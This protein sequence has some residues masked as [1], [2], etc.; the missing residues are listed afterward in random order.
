MTKRLGPSLLRIRP[1]DFKEERLP[2]EIREMVYVALIRTTCRN[3]TIGAFRVLACLRST[4]RACHRLVHHNFLV[5]LLEALYQRKPQVGSLSIRDSN[6][7]L[8]LVPYTKQVFAT[9]WSLFG[10][11]VYYR[12]CSLVPLQRLSD[13][14]VYFT[15]GDTLGHHF[16]FDL[17]AKEVVPLYANKNLFLVEG[18]AEKR[19]VMKQQF[20]RYIQS[21][22]DEDDCS[23]L[24]QLLLRPSSTD[25][26]SFFLKELLDLH[27]SPETDTGVVKRREQFPLKFSPLPDDPSTTKMYNVVFRVP[28][29]S[30]APD[31]RL[32][33]VSQ[34]Q[35]LRLL[36]R[37]LFRIYTPNSLT[38]VA[39]R[40][41]MAK[42]AHRLASANAEMQYRRHQLVL[43]RPPV[44]IDIT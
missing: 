44:I 7:L 15:E 31:Y 22:A 10:L 34:Q 27:A 20:E 41:G 30:V 6:S 9:A 32:L 16:Y 28:G 12:E 39:Y 36:K 2:L 3:T 19:T 21:F 1:L 23:R 18:I 14:G 40:L 35:E 26:R 38:D 11:L 37:R 33:T 25:A 5:S 13:G 17:A 29:D 4:E 43:S 8:D 24:R 42:K